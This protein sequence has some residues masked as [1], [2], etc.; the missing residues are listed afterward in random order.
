MSR[1]KRNWFAAIIG[2]IGEI[3]MTLGVLLLLFV[4]WELWWTNFD[5]EK[6]QKVA[7]QELFTET[8][9]QELTGELKLGEGEVFGVMYAPRLG[10]NYAVPISEGTTDE[11]LNTVGL[12]RYTES[13]WPGE[14]GNFAI[15]GHRQTHGAVLWNMD[16]FQDG[17]KVYVQTLQKYYTYE[18][19]VIKVVQPNQSE[20]IAANPFDPNQQPDESWLTLTTCHPPYTTLERMITHAKLVDERPASDGPPAEIKEVV[21]KTVN[22]AQSG[23]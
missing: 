14:V 18:V 15:A 22:A 4:V 1:R 13:Q 8:K 12:G 3:L 9:E 16:K 21:E 19:E 11:V 6:A 20:V 7:T 23:L 10:E 2:F 17:D 5:A